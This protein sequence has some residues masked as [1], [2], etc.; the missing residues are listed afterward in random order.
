MLFRSVDFFTSQPTIPGF[1]L[2]TGKPI[3]RSNYGFKDID[4]DFDSPTNVQDWTGHQNVFQSDTRYDDAGTSTTKKLGSGEFRFETLYNP[5]QTSKL[6]SR[7]NIR[8]GK[9]GYRESFLGWGMNEPYFVTD[10]RYPSG[11]SIF[12]RD[13]KSVV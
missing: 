11:T 2:N 7:L 5:D 12:G 10:M 4:S 13:R 9:G 3:D 8:L 6:D 1:T